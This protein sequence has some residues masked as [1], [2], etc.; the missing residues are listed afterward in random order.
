[1]RLHPTQAQAM[2]I[3]GKERVNAIPKFPKGHG[4]LLLSDSTGDPLRVA[5]GNVTMQDLTIFASQ[6]PPSPLPFATRAKEEASDAAGASYR[7][8]F[9]PGEWD[10]PGRHD[11]RIVDAYTPYTDALHGQPANVMPF[12]KSS[13]E[14]PVEPTTGVSGERQQQEYL[15]SDQEITGFLAAYKVSYNIDKALAAVGRGSSRYR[16][17]ARRVIAAYGLREEA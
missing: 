9:T 5:A 2:R 13:A 16:P 11:A 17:A 10:F 15:L 7:Q 8:P 14:L 4:F 12:R 6:L 3:L 1:M